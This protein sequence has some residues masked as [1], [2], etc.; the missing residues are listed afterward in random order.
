[1]PDKNWVKIRTETD[2]FAAEII[3]TMLEDHGIHCVLVNKQISAY[4]HI[5]EI[6]IFVSSEQVVMATHLLAKSSI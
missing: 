6:E 5:G 4:Q 3:R 2:Q 1:M